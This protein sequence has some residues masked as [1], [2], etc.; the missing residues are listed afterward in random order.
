[1]V[2]LISDTKTQILQGLTLLCCIATLITSSKNNVVVYYMS[3]FMLLT[4]SHMPIL[5][6]NIR[7]RCLW[8]VHTKQVVQIHLQRSKNQHG[9]KAKLQM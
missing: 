4:M 9:I 6:I 8:E 5:H 1:M 3:S 7:D 2:S